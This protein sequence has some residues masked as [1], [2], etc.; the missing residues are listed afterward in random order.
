MG[1]I[2]SA[3]YTRLSG[4]AG[5]SALVSTRIY[6]APIPET[7]TYPLVTYM[8][9]SGVRVYAMSNQTPLVDARFQVDSWATT[10]TGVRALAEQVR[11]ALSAYS[12][13]SDSVVIDLITLEN[14]QKIYDDEAGL[15]RVIQDYFIAYRETQPA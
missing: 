5:L 7:P 6:P 4:F 13:T 10:S 1:T 3:I 15:H 11:L 9:V 8:Q 12:G 14:E 2:D